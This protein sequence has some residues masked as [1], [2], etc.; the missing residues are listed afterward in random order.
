MPHAQEEVEILLENT[1]ES[2]SSFMQ[3]IALA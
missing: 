3:L 1:A 2:I